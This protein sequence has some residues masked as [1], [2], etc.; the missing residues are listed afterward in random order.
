M[1]ERNTLSET[2]PTSALEDA[3]AGIDTIDDQIHD[4][5]MKR[6]QLVRFIG[7]AKRGGGGAYRPAREAHILRRLFAR[8]EPP[9]NFSIVYSLWREMIG[10]FTAMQ[11]PL[12]VS[13][14]DGAGLERLARDHFG[15]SA[16][17]GTH[18][19]DK[20]LVEAMRADP[21]LLAII[22]KSG[23]R[24]CLGDES[25]NIISALPFYGDRIDAFCLSSIEPQESGSDLTLFALNA[26][27]PNSAD[28]TCIDGSGTDCLIVQSGFRTGEPGSLE[29]L[30]SDCGVKSD[31]L[32]CIGAYPVPIRQIET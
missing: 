4:L 32:Q 10:G 18:G 22:P 24:V 25:P 7:S 9:L 8:H 2:E 30:A 15:A 3:R 17:V 31:A 6:A 19:S 29:G 16:V 12:R 11:A 23:W 27:A 1:S 20:E 14:P 26:P 28:I 13:V 5:L 21:S